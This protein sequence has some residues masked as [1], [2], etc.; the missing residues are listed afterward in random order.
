MSLVVANDIALSLLE[1]TQIPSYFL[2][3]VKISKETRERSLYFKAMYIQEPF[4]MTELQ[5]E[6]EPSKEN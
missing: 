5:R 1:A 3:H 6:L 4:K 2:G